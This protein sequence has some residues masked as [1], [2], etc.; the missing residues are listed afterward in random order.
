MSYQ[1]D[2]AVVCKNGH[3]VSGN[4][5]NGK[6]ALYCEQCGEATVTRCD[7]CNSPIRG[8]S[9]YSGHFISMGTLAAFCYQ[10]GKPYEWTLRQIQAAK[11]LADE[12]EGLDGAELSKAKDSFIVLVSDTPQT[13]VAAARVTKLLQKAGPVIG[14]G[15]RDIVVSIATDAA[16]KMMGL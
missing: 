15:I 2:T 8:N 7:T 4:E 11:D 6:A 10:C 16:K 12:V 14:G 3:V 13:P 9:T 5:T 1:Y